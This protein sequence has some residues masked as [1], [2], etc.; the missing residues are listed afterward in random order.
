MTMEVRGLLSQATLVMSGH[1]SG[2]S[3][4]KRPNPV[5]I[6]TP[7]SHKLRDLSR[8]VNTS[9]QVSTP[10]DAEM[11]EASLEEIPSVIS[12]IAQAPGP[13]SGTP[14]ADASHL[15]ERANKVLGELLATESSINAC[16][17]KVVWELGM[18]LHQNDSETTESIKE[19]R[20]IFTLVT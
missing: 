7:P 13:S 5:V 1:M 17:H 9:S 14:P 10:D 16:R 2:N 12:P 8:P 11:V 6:L 4:P 3:T 15:Q 18:E 20:A 19:A